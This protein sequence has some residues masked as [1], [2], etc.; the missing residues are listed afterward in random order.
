MDVPG[1]STPPSENPERKEPRALRRV[2]AEW[3]QVASGARGRV[4]ERHSDLR[5]R[6][7]PGHT[8][9]HRYLVKMLAHF[10]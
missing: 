9:S 5:G 6:T 1:Y 2:T 3:R 7:S 8:A 10:P 4:T